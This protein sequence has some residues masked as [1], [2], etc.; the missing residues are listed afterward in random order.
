MRSLL[1]L[2]ALVAVAFADSNSTV[3]KAEY[4]P[5]SP[6]IIDSSV[7]IVGGFD[8]VRNQ[9]PYQV[10]LQRRSITSAYS[11]ICGGSIIS[12]NWILTAAHCT[13]AGSVYRI[14]AGIILQNDQNIP[15]Q[16]S[17]DVEEVFNHPG[18]PGNNVVAPD[19]V[20]LVR[21]AESLVYAENVQSIPI[22][23]HGT[24]HVG[25]SILSGWGITI[26][27]GSIP[28]HLQCANLPII[29]EEECN[30]ILNSLLGVNGNPFD[31]DR[32]VCSGL[33]NPGQSACS[34]DSGGPLVHD[35]VLIGIVSWV[36]IPCGV[37]NSP[38]VYAKASAYSNWVVN[39]T[40]GEVRP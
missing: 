28:N 5:S 6:T 35:G 1:V 37:Y 40:D 18:Y 24:R 3:F 22:P 2:S 13:P 14:V 25:E 9:F 39:V 31:I 30:S 11:H 32:N 17:I 29:P 26:P 36:L 10:S 12:R 4:Y 21:L 16:Q 27:G 7:R 15:G 23:V 34:G 38:S 19:D 33:T 20:S 8:A